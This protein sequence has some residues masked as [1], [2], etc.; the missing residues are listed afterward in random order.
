M[1]Q[2]GDSSTRKPAESGV[3]SIDLSVVS[4]AYWGR[5]DEEPD[6]KAKRLL[7][8]RVLSVM[9]EE[10]RLRKR[11]QLHARNMAEEDREFL[12]RYIRSQRELPEFTFPS[13]R[14]W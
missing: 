12:S 13:E 11:I 9:H 14:G 5:D 1:A 7:S 10:R 3:S 6:E 2:V 8:E 4:E